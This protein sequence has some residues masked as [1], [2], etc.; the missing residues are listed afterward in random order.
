MPSEVCGVGNAGNGKL[1]LVEKLRLRCGSWR[2]G[3]RQFGR[4]GNRLTLSLGQ[5]RSE[6]RDYRQDRGYEASCAISGLI[7]G[8]AKAPWDEY[9]SD[10]SKPFRT[11]E[12]QF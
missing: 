12:R 2:F 8:H 11:L 6:K 5:E 9:E 4:I 7:C 10:E 1:G 3:R